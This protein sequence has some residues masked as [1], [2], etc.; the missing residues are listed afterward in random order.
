MSLILPKWFYLLNTVPIN[1]P[2]DFFLVEIEK[3][4]LKFKINII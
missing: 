1:I 4:T 3:L 2:A